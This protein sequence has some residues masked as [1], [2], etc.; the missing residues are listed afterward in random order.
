MCNAFFKNTGG[1]VYKVFV[2]S[3]IFYFLKQSKYFNKN[4]F[5]VMVSGKK[6]TA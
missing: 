3:G 2:K 6:T 4:M 5:N 1:G